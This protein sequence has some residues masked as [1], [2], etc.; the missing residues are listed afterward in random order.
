MCPAGVH[1]VT[2]FYIADFYIADFYI[3]SYDFAREYWT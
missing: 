2:S 1:V 3:A